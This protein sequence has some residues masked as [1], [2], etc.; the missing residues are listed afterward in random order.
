M[1]WVKI[2]DAA[3]QHPKLLAVDSPA[4][5]W[6]WVCGLAYCNRQKRHDGFIPRAA[7]ALLYPI[8]GAAKLAAKLV[9]AGLWEEIEGGYRVHDYHDYQP[10]ADEASE[11]SRARSE[12][13]RKGG[14]QSGDSRRSKTEANCF[15]EAKQIA[16]SKTKQTCEANEPPSRSRPDPVPIRP[17]DPDPEKDLPHARARVDGET[18]LQVLERIWCNELQRPPTG[19]ATAKRQAVKRYGDAAK[20]RGHPF[21]DFLRRASFAFRDVVAFYE[22]AAADGQLDHPPP[23]LTVEAFAGYGRTADYV[24]TVLDWLDGKKPVLAKKPQAGAKPVSRGVAPLPK[25]F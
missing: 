14:K 17:Q 21:E 8:P 13:G 3:P 9:T 15:N 11:I 16:S 19:D 10:T 25:G 24:P 1:A 7:V 23:R 4:A 18:E 22:Q 5:C 20:A 2:D 12:A 6:L